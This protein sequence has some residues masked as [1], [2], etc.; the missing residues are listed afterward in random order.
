M[1][2][3]WGPYTVLLIRIINYVSVSKL[4]I[5]KEGILAADDSKRLASLELTVFPRAIITPPFRPHPHHNHTLAGP[6]CPYYAG[7]GEYPT[8]EEE[9]VPAMPER[10]Y[11]RLRARPT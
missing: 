10:H 8:D 6:K 1:F 11:S 7:N 4:S 3:G 9:T 2:A 5:G